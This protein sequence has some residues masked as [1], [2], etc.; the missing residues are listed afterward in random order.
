MKKII[1][2]AIIFTAAIVFTFFT[3]YRNIKIENIKNGLVTINILGLNFDYYYESE[4]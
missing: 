1:N 4:E 3:I 2:Y